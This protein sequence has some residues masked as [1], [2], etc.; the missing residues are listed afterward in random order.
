MSERRLHMRKLIDARVRIYHSQFGTLDGRIRD[1]SEGGC[2]VTLDNIPETEGD[3]F[4]QVQC[5]E[6]EFITLKPINMD[7]VFRMS[8]IR[9]LDNSVILQFEDCQQG[10]INADAL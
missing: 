5:D 9:K 4:A 10:I 2:C 7:V 3:L 8:C 6:D 1:I